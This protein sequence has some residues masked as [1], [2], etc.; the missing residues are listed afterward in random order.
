MWSKSEQ[1]ILW[2]VTYI[3][4][5]LIMIFRFVVSNKI[6]KLN[7]IEISLLKNTISLSP[8][9]IEALIVLFILAIS[10]LLYKVTII[11]MFKGY[12]KQI[13]T[14]GDGQDYSIRKINYLSVNDYSFFLLTLL[15][16]LVSI[17]HTSVI[18]LAVSII[19]IFCVIS[20]Y[21]KTDSISSCPLFFF[22]GRRVYKGIISQGTKEEESAD[23]SLRKEVVIIL[24]E[25]NLNLNGKMRGEELVNN[26]FYLTNK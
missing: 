3:P 26:V 17:D 19:I 1:I 21:V 24:K 8:L 6:I 7:Q 12:E 4:L 14:G 16:P 20:I 25:E 11:Y 9:I 15:L 22:S 13:V 2:T 5:I 10:F 18:N 23:S